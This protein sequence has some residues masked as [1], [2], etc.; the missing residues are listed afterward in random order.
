[1]SATQQMQVIGALLNEGDD[2]AVS[3]DINDKRGAAEYHEHP[4]GGLFH[5]GHALTCSW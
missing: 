2:P 1:M 4:L 3:G 5:I